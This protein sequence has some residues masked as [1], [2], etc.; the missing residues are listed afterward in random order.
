[1][2]V[3]RGHRRRRPDGDPIA[4][5]TLGF[6]AGSDN[7][8]LLAPTDPAYQAWAKEEAA[9]TGR[10][11]SPTPLFAWE[12][13]AAGQ[14]GA[15]SA[16]GGNL[17]EQVK[18]LW[19]TEA[20]ATPAAA[21]GIARRIDA[22]SK[23]DPHAIGDSGTSYGIYQHHGSRAI[24]LAEWAEKRGMNPADPIVQTRFASP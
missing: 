2:L 18:Q 6:L 10:T 12:K 1:M 11:Y 19:I 23:F 20:G 14:A 9:K 4:D 15:P 21:E 16:A 22:E 24:G 17:R 5:G 3:A 13:K 7:R 8:G